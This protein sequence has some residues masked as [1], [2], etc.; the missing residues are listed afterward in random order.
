MMDETPVHHIDTA[1]F[2]FGDI[3]S[4]YAETRRLNP[5]IHG[6]A[7]AILTVRHANNML[8]TID[9]RSFLDKEDL[10]PT[11]D[12]AVFEGE[13]GAIRISALGEIWSKHEKIW[14]DDFS[15]GSPGDS[16]CAALAHF[17][18]C[19]ESCQPF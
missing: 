16:I 9:G 8:G 7:Q 6:E 5:I 14:T 12:D 11:M 10:G 13:S 15:T 3:S 4:I 17:T 19:L 18:S 2:L 1:R